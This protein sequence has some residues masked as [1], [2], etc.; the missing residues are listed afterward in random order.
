MGVAPP[1][2]PRGLSR[3]KT[4]P[5]PLLTRGLHSPPR[6]PPPPQ[7]AVADMAQM[8]PP[9]LPFTQHT[10]SR[11]YVP[12]LLHAAGMVSP[13]TRASRGLGSRDVVG[14][15]R[16]VVAAVCDGVVALWDETTCCVSNNRRT[17]WEEAT[18][19]TYAAQGSKPLAAVF[20]KQPA[21]A[22]RP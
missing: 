1:R 18:P 17:A 22:G 5:A 10:N 20:E 19:L 21:A 11:I 6:A 2:D 8:P 7:H 4:P 15:W 3:P 16:R 9:S 12:L 14:E 13:E